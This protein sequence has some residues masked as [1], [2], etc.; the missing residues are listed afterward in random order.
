M[1][2]TV[3]I[4]TCSVCC[5]GTVQGFAKEYTHTCEAEYLEPV[6]S[7]SLKLETSSNTRNS[8]SRA[9]PLDGLRFCWVPKVSWCRT[10]H[11]RSAWDLRLQEAL[12][13]RS[14]DSHTPAARLYYLAKLQQ[15]SKNACNSKHFSLN[16]YVFVDLGITGTFPNC[17]TPIGSVH[18]KSVDG[19][20]RLTYRYTQ[21]K[22][23]TLE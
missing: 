22:E 7:A 19:T 3:G 13:S 14:Q 2:Q 12:R 1:S 6:R 8:P 17:S 5:C 11:Y 4:E 9:N 23:S 21:D 20:T 15:F 10:S 16:R 18:P